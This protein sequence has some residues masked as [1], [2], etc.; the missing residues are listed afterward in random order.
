M[1]TLSIL[2][3]EVLKPFFQNPL[4]TAS[5][6]LPS[7]AILGEEGRALSLLLFP[8]PF[9]SSFSVF[10]S[11]Y[12]H[13]LSFLNYNLTV[14]LWPFLPSGVSPAQYS[15][16][17]SS[18]AIFCEARSILLHLL[19]HVTRLSVLF[20]VAL[21]FCRHQSHSLRMP[22]HRCVACTRQ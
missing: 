15:L 11:S 3:R 1:K 13:L 18:Q 7:A 20:A 12:F 21:R 6:S 14:S 8:P 9:F 19:L 10:C 22:T 16:P 2:E 5:L 17:T 4:P